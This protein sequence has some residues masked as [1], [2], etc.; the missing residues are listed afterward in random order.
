MRRLQSAIA[1]GLLFSWVQAASAFAQAAGNGAGL[2]DA[3]T[4]LDLLR[5]LPSGRPGANAGWGSAAVPLAGRAAGQAAIVG[6]VV[7]QVRAK[8]VIVTLPA[9]ADGASVLALSRRLGLE[10]DTLYTSPLLGQRVVRLRIPDQRSIETVLGQV[11][12][13]TEIIVA[14]PHYVYELNQGAA[15]PLPVPQ[16]APEKL[17]LAEAHKMAQGKRIK[18]AVI[19]TQID[20]AHPAL[21]GAVTETYDAIGETKPEPELHGTALAAIVGAR[22]ELVG[23]APGASVIGIRAFAKGTAGPAQSYTLALIKSLDFA[24]ASGARVVNMSFAGPEDPLLGK[25]IAAAEQQGVVVVAAA[26][27]GGPTA[28]PAYPAAFPDVI[29]VTATD[30]SDQTYKDAN[31]GAYIGIAAPG[32]DII[33]AAP[34]GA[35][36]I[37]SG[38]S[39]AAAHVSGI[40]ALL[41]EKNPKLMPK[42]VRAILAKSAHATPGKSADETGAGMADA[43]AAVSAVK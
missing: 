29:A 3:V 43:A 33:S 19:D 7:P 38:T 32:V 41:L 24:V 30:S 20:V 1:L 16:Y 4:V 36:D 39:L 26:G 35:Y 37:S 34:K 6:A 15:K 10:G 8:E 17:H 5:R 21:K 12:A 28:R 11:A 31:H 9:R 23:V 27:N 18:I 40:V 42:D 2:P 14:Q 25:A 22:A 13:E